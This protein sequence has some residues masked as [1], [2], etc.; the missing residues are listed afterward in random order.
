[1]YVSPAAAVNI[2]RGSIS[3]EKGMELAFGLSFLGV[4]YLFAIFRLEVPSKMS[5]T[6]FGDKRVPGT[7]R[8]RR[9]YPCARFSMH[10]SNDGVPIPLTAMLWRRNLIFSFPRELG[11]FNYCGLVRRGWELP[12]LLEKRRQIVHAQYAL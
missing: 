10:S 12:E 2:P 3:G 1:M 11:M 6:V 9:A 7:L 5:L 8:A 4:K